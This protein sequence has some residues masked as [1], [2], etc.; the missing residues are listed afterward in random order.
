M[1]REHYARAFRQKLPPPYSRQQPRHCQRGSQHK[2]PGGL[3][4]DNIVD[5]EDAQ[6][7]CYH[8]AYEE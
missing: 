7:N 1:R 6:A 4:R 8:Q 2:A 5:P 3:L